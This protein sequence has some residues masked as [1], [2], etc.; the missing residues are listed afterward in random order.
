MLVTDLV[1][2]Y[3]DLVCWHCDLVWYSALVCW[4]SDLVCWHS[5]SVILLW[6]ILI[7]LFVS[8]F[9]F[10][11]DILFILFKIARWASSGKELSYCFSLVMFYLMPSQLFLFLSL[12]L[13]WA[14]CGM[15]L[16][17]AFELTWSDLIL[18]QWSAVRPSTAVVVHT[19]KLEDLR[20]QLANIY[21]I[22]YVASLGWM[23]GFIRF[24]G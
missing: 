11:F 3:S 23:K 8:C 6:F 12:L 13:S 17:V 16:I 7:V 20:D 5:D 10:L 21:Q 14:E 4:H 1:C 15:F 19:F 18:Y 22:L 9:L 24:W 2:W